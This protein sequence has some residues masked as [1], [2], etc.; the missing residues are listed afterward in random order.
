MPL[1]N[2]ILIADDHPMLLEGL[3]KE[4][5]R[6]KYTK[7]SQAKNGIEAL[8]LITKHTP[9]IAILDIEMPVLNAF[10]VINKAII[11]QTKT[12]YIIL[13]SHKEHGFIIKA[14]QLNISGYILKDEPFAEL[15]KCIKAVASGG[16]FFSDSFKNVITDVISPEVEKINFLSP[17]E[18]TIL[19]LVAKGKSS[20]DIAEILRISPRTVQKH[21]AN[22]IAKLDLPST[23][24]A[25]YSWCITYKEL[26]LSL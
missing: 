18:R 4:L 19:R 17:S 13:T 23:G 1:N 26:L 7:V 24:N 8:T 25:L 16:Q 5:V 22:I 11:E 15:N 12:K 20:K 9:D 6:A 21:R 14:K 10:E 2:T 3:Y